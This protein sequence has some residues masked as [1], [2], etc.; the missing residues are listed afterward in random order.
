MHHNLVRG[1]QLKSTL[2]EALAPAITGPTT[3][4]TP[5][6]KTDTTNDSAEMTQIMAYSVHQIGGDTSINHSY[7]LLDEFLAHNPQNSQPCSL[8][9]PHLQWNDFTN[10]LRN[11]K[12]SKAGGPR[13]M[14]SLQHYLGPSQHL[15]AQF[16]RL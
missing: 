7:E 14:Q 3:L 8:Q 16:Q 9:V 6:F 11:Y 1:I 12:P 10:K 15:G 2:N 13:Q 4:Y 5:P